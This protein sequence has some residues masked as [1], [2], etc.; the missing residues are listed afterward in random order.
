MPATDSWTYSDQTPVLVVTDK[1]H[2][3]VYEVF[4]NG[5]PTK[6][7]E[8]SLLSI[9]S[10]LDSI[11]ASSAN[12][13]VLSSDSVGDY[14][15]VLDALFTGVTVIIVFLAMVVGILLARFITSRMSR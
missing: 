10:S 1:E 2:N 8:T 13:L 7:Y 5:L 3:V 14:S 12:Q 6:D 9:Q 15:P 4:D 11:S